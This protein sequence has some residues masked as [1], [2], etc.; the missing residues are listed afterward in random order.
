[1]QRYFVPEDHFTEHHVVITGDDARH[2]QKVMRMKPS[3]SLICANNK[4]K[5]YLCAVESIDGGQVCA[6][7]KQK[8]TGNSELP[9]QV[10][11]A[12]GIP[13]ADKFDTIIQ[14]GTECGAS[15]FIPFQAQRSI[16]LWK[17][18]KKDKKRLR[19]EKI[20]KEAAEQS[21]R[22]YVPKLSE[23][24]DLDQL[25]AYSTSCDYKMVAF[26][27]TAKSGAQAGF[28]TLLK[29]MNKGDR[30]LAVIGPEGGLSVDE[31]K[32]LED[33][34]FVLCGLGP[35]IL[36]TETT[37]IYLLSAISYHFELLNCEVDD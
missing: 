26:E 2:I 16:A 25:I 11:I 35:R 8:I 24:M 36:R 31:A 6:V 13:K 15:L 18:N 34:G 12:Q 10:T 27:E 7:I 5:A 9:I 28:P 21:H 37:A 1:M 22:L 23:P 20:S 29:K 33:H 19:L 14:K 4:G 3:D 30:L 32:K 17:K